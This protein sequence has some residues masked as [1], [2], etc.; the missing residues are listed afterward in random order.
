M[1]PCRKNFGGFNL[2]EYK[3]NKSK[4]CKADHI[5]QDG[6]HIV[7]DTEK[8]AMFRVLGVGNCS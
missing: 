7:W 1:I 8:F 3:E 6:A 4:I 2:K 5:L